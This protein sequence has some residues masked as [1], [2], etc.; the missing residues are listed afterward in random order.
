MNKSQSQRVSSSMNKSQ[1]QR[2]SPREEGMRVISSAYS[3]NIEFFISTLDLLAKVRDLNIERDLSKLQSVYPE[4]NKKISELMG[5]ALQL[6]VYKWLDRLIIDIKRFIPLIESFKGS[7]MFSASQKGILLLLVR[8]VVSD[9]DKAVFLP[10]EQSEKLEVILEWIVADYN[11]STGVLDH[12]FAKEAASAIIKS[13]DINALFAWVRIALDHYKN[14]VDKSGLDVLSPRSSDFLID[15]FLHD[16]DT[17]ENERHPMC[18]WALM[19][20]Q[21]LKDVYGTIDVENNSNDT[22]T[23]DTE[24]N[25]ETFNWV[26]RLD[27]KRKRDLII[28]RSVR[29]DDIRIRHLIARESLSF[30]WILSYQ[31]LILIR[32][33]MASP[34]M[35][36]VMVKKH[37]DEKVLSPRILRIR[38]R[39]VTPSGDRI[40]R[41]EMMR[42]RHK[43][44]LLAFDLFQIHED[45]FQRLL[46]GLKGTSHELVESL[47][48]IYASLCETYTELLDFLDYKEIER[49]LKCSA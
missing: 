31:I 3:E 23:V 32:L 36:K 10:F 25:Q 40:P 8:E 30:Q 49:A 35:T 37:I 6:A 24:E 29:D 42:S 27:A 16:D 1:S 45:D 20:F 39:S 12:R 46:K 33:I 15:E 19:F 28:S 26:P 34:S 43:G 22:K 48:D 14:K 21:E 47:E 7:F 41:I 9:T 38:T 11:Y 44:T 5:T 17:P 18:E 13:I 2:V 4:V